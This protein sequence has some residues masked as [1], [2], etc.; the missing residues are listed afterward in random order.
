[1]IPIFRILSFCSARCASYGRTRI[2][3]LALFSISCSFPHSEPPGRSDSSSDETS[4]DA[5]PQDS[6]IPLPK[7]IETAPKPIDQFVGSWKQAGCYTVG[8]NGSKRSLTI[9]STQRVMTDDR[10]SATDCL[11]LDFQ[12]YYTNTIV[13]GAPVQIANASEA[14]EFDVTLVKTEIMGKSAALVD[15][16][17]LDVAYGFSDWAVD[18]KKNV[19]GLNYD[20]TPGGEAAGLKY[21]SVI[22]MTPDGIAEGAF[23]TSAAARGTVLGFPYANAP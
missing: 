16:F 6:V 2:A 19:T 12:V 13:L 15:Q 5:P 23:S 21:Y 11:Q 7:E 3:L 18:V 17:N 20:G 8:A 1:M 9:S 22:A 10:Y 4:S 14:Y